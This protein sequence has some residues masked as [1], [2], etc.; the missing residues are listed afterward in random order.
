MNSARARDLL[1]AADVAGLAYNL[2][3]ESDIFGYLPVCQLHREV[4][5]VDETVLCAL[6]AFRNDDRTQGLV[7]GPPVYD[8][9]DPR[10]KFKLDELCRLRE[11]ADTVQ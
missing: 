7:A 10:W 2:L 11:L 8:R 4:G 3:V 5:R 1:L 6:V 9:N